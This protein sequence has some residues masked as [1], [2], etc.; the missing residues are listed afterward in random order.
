MPCQRL[1]D[2]AIGKIL[3]KEKNLKLS[4]QP[5]RSENQS[6]SGE[7][8]ETEIAIS[9]THILAQQPPHTF[10]NPRTYKKISNK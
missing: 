7:N 9:T 4:D 3:D 5:N 1:K 8:S 10:Q 2:E 6:E